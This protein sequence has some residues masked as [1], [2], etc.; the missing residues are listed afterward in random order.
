MLQQFV[1]ALNPSNYF[2]R[3]WVTKER[4][5]LGS[6]PVSSMV[7]L[8]NSHSDYSDCSVMSS[9]PEDLGTFSMFVLLHET[10]Q[11][12]QSN[13]QR[14]GT[15]LS[16]P[17]YGRVAASLVE[18]CK[19]PLRPPQPCVCEKAG[20]AAESDRAPANCARAADSASLTSP[21]PGASRHTATTTTFYTSESPA[22]VYRHVSL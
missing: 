20:N 19:N 1:C 15:L 22:T 16:L 6:F 10:K 13:S 4:D 2:P 5:R 11:I 3:D 14:N 21:L 18:T 17:V 8:K 7:R 12:C 9:L